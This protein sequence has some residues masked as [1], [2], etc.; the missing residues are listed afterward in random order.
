MHTSSSALKGI[1]T[2]KQTHW[3][4][5]IALEWREM[6]EKCSH[7]KQDE[8]HPKSLYILHSKL[9]IIPISNIKWTNGQSYEKCNE[10][11]KLFFVSFK[12]IPKW[13]FIV[14]KW[15]SPRESLDTAISKQVFISRTVSLTVLY[16]EVRDC[17]ARMRM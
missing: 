5:S 3:A 16:F 7:F 10:A 13:N 9:N 1:D 8:C 11:N 17:V 2:M 15:N 12:R 6:K 4:N 14:E